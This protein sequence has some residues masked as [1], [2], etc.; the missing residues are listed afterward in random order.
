[1]QLISDSF[2]KIN[3]QLHRDVKEYGKESIKWV[4]HFWGMAEAM[5]PETILDY[6]CGKGCLAL[7]VPFFVTSYDPCVKQYASLP[8]PCDLVFCVNVLEC[9]EPEYLDEVISHIYYLTKKSV[10]FVIN[11][12]LSEAKFLDGRNFHLNIKSDQEWRDRIEKK[13]TILNHGGKDDEILIICEPPGIKRTEL[14]SSIA[15]SPS[16]SLN[17]IPIGSSC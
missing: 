4:N 15:I 13:F 7:N 1:M 9:V 3:A 5:E 12:A 14:M 6:G 16:V 10:V 11:T 17:E 8:Q 2:R